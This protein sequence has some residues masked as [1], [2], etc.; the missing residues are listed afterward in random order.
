V[1]PEQSASVPVCSTVPDV[2]PSSP[3]QKLEY[4]V[5]PEHVTDGSVHEAETLVYRLPVT[6]Y[7]DQFVLVEL[8][9]LCIRSCLTPEAVP[10]LAESATAVARTPTMVTQT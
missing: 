10:P 9:I 7:P 6:A 8:L 3:T 5:V 2:S 4:A 1:E